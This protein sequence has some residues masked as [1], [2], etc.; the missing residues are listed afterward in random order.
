MIVSVLGKLALELGE[1]GSDPLGFLV[2]SAELAN[3]PPTVR[4]LLR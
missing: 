2:A 1:K 3:A 4:L